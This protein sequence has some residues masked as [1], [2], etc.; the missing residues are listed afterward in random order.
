M[1]PDPKTENDFRKDL[2][3]SNMDGIYSAAMTGLTNSFVTPLGIAM[4]ASSGAIAMLSSLPALIGSYSQLLASKLV[5]FVPNRRKIIVVSAFVQ[6]L[7]WIPII[8]LPFVST[9]ILWLITLVCVHALLANLYQPLWTSLMGDIVPQDRRGFFFGRRN[10]YIVLFTFISML[11]AGA[12]L[13]YFGKSNYVGFAI[14]FGAAILCQM[15]STGYKAQLDTTL[16]HDR[17]ESDFSLWQFLHKGHRTDFGRFVVFVSIMKFAVN[18]ANP[19]F[20]VY[21]LSSLKFDYLTFTLILSS[22]V[23]FKYLTMDMWGA[24][25]DRAGNRRVMIVTS[26]FVPFIAGLWIFFVD[27]VYLFFVEALSGF[28]WAG[29]D[30][31]ISN[32]IFDAVMPQNTIKC[33]AYYNAIVGKAIFFGASMGGLFIAYV[34]SLGFVSGIPVVFFVSAVFRVAAL[35]LLPSIRELR[36][37]SIKSGNS[38]FFEDGVYINPI[39]RRAIE[40]IRPHEPKVRTGPLSVNPKPGVVERRMITKPSPYGPE[41]ERKFVTRMM[42]GVG[43]TDG[44]LR[45]E[46]TSDKVLSKLHKGKW[47]DMK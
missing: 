31:A 22:S 15:I 32:Y 35:F 21:M 40:I 3:N 29:L 11:S 4:G 5:S 24:I 34:P 26:F 25:I 19:F 42:K 10:K 36:L 23:I 9:S 8:I 41:V 2:H 6:A 46:P 30:L 39:H 27:P 43:G 20:A 38:L 14:I 17:K 7:S 18:I 45:N 33:S 28:T 13:S 1:T 37:I 47:R 16:R 12:V 44:T